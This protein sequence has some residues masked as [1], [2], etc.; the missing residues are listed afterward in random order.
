MN[1]V[2]QKMGIHEWSYDNA[3]SDDTRHKVPWA[4][5]EA[6]LASIRAAREAYARFAL[7]RLAA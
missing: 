1:L 2:S 6:A 7:E 5:A 3:P 4:K